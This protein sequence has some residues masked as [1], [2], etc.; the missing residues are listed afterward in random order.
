[1]WK[2]WS[3]VI[4][5]I[6]LI[7]SGLIAGLQEPANLLIIGILAI[8]FGFWDYKMWQGILNGVLGLWMFISGIS[9]S[10]ITPT[11]ILT[12]GIIMVISSMWSL[13]QQ[14]RGIVTHKAV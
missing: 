9:I 1:M 13:S 8:V 6:W 11:N 4:L 14:R 10:L 5:G 7:I 2:G 3:T 12:I